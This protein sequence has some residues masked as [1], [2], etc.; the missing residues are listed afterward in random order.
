M[1][2]NTVPR[3]LLP[4]FLSG[5]QAHPE[6]HLCA[7]TPQPPE[8]A[9]SLHPASAFLLDP[10]PGANRREPLVRPL[11]LRLPAHLGTHLGG[12]D[13]AR[14]VTTFTMTNQGLRHPQRASLLTSACEAPVPSA[15]RPRPASPG[16]PGHV[17][18]LQRPRP[19]LPPAHGQPVCKDPPT[20][21]PSCPPRPHHSHRS[22]VE[23][24]P[25]SSGS[26]ATAWLCEQSPGGTES[27]APSYACKTPSVTESSSLEITLLSAVHTSCE[28]S[29]AIKGD[30]GIKGGHSPG[31]AWPDSACVCSSDL[32]HGCVC[33][34]TCLL[35]NNEGI[36]MEHTASSPKTRVGTCVWGVHSLPRQNQGLQ[37][38][39]PRFPDDAP[40]SAGCRLTPS[41][42]RQ[43]LAPCVAGSLGAMSLNGAGAKRRALSPPGW[44]DPCASVCCL[45]LPHASLS[46]GFQH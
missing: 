40:Q 1:V 31:R 39:D 37:L 24:G 6:P 27:T 41:S 29:M 3:S 23:A 11:P 12:A 14:F 45:G 5:G 15:S 8:A 43:R 28:R 9:S 7:A 34:H 33:L 18:P 13:W 21:T 42:G 46:W 4:P 16:A 35:I 38:R 32:V 36:H 44:N 19:T 2:P 25:A 10:C 26:R 30:A 17:A 20:T 22:Q